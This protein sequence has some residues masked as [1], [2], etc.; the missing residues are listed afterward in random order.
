VFGNRQL[1]QV[2]DRDPL[3]VNFQDS[4]TGIGVDTDENV[5][6]FRARK[7]FAVGAPGAFSMLVNG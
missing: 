6:Y 7:A 2:G 3:A 5:L 4:Q 1:L